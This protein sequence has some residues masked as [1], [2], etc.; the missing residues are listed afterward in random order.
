MKKKNLKFPV[1]NKDGEKLWVCPRCGR[2]H[3]QKTSKC[4]GCKYKLKIQNR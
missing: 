4:A 1:L 3:F 2:E